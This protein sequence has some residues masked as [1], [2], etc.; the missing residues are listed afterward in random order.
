MI[1]YAHFSK[2][3]DAANDTVTKAED[4]LFAAMLREYP[5]KARVYVLHSR[6]QYYGRIVGHDVR[7]R[8]IGVENDT[9]G[10]IGWR[11]YREVGLIDSQAAGT[12]EPSRVPD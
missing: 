8:R 9:S 11:W 10:K 6:G 1:Q 12:A 2:V 4:Q 3:V 5:L 7:G